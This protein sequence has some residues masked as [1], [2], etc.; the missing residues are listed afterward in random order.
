MTT[1]L[2][3]ALDQALAATIGEGP[4]DAR[5]AVARIETLGGELIWEGAAGRARGDEVSPM[6]PDR[7]FHHASIGKTYTAAVILR[8]MEE[9]ALGEAGLDTALASLGLFQPSVLRRLHIC[10]GVDYSAR[11]T[12]RHL[13]THTAGIRDAM[14]DDP[15]TIGGPAP[16]SLIG[17]MRREN[18]NPT[19]V[20]WNGAKPEDP[21]AGVLN[22]YI[23][24]GIGEHALSPPGQRFHYSDT[25]FVILALLAEHLGQT[26]LEALLARY[27][28]EPLGLEDTYMA[29]RTDPPGLGTA[30]QPESDVWAGAR[31]FISENVSLSFDWGGGGT[32]STASD[33]CRFS[34]G[35]RDGLVFRRHETYETM[36][37]WIAPPGMALPRLGV[38]LGYFDTAYAPGELW[39]HSG[40]WGAKMFHD[41]KRGVAFAGTINQ[42]L[43]R[44]DWHH[45]LIEVAASATSP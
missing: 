29:Y 40:A 27:I 9:G 34:R 1:N 30:R 35:L 16:G 2:S 31:P 15:V 25:G 6:D 7:P 4:R 3:A 5:G 14:I 41:P 36:T 33:L 22:F 20:G 8:L 17:R 19:W 43:G 12:L 37:D 13:L 45:H 32:V 42:S 24:E 28:F 39:G 11:I 44:N 21:F 38:G 26:S 10:E 18:R 23:A